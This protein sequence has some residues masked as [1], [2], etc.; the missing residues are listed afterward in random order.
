[1][2]SMVA[3]FWIVVA[4]F[5]I[6]GAIRGWA[7]ELLVTFSVVLAFFIMAVLDTYTRW[8]AGL[9]SMTRMWLRIG[10]LLLLAFFGYQTP[11]IPRVASRGHFVREKIQDT[12]LGLILGAF[13]GYLLVGSLW[14]FL[15]EAGYPFP[16]LIAPP[17]PGVMLGEQALTL[18]KYAPP[19]WLSSTPT[20]Y[21]AIAF[22]FLFVIVVFI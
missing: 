5:A 14:Y 3:F 18:L 19:R 20:V 11:S 13:N 22:A 6:I 4:L 2:L 7:K 10:I 16:N 15:H 1:M 12:L 21:F 8:T 9:A 17:E